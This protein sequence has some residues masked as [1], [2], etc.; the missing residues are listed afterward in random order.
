MNLITYKPD[1]MRLLPTLLFFLS[2]SN[3]LIAQ[4]KP[5][6]LEIR[7]GANQVQLNYD[8]DFFETLLP[9]DDFTL[10]TARESD[11]GYTFGVGGAKNIRDR[12]EWVTNLDFVR[13]EYATQSGVYGSNGTLPLQE[14]GPDVPV[15]LF[16]IKDFSF[17]NIET[18]IRYYLKNRNKGFFA[19][20]FLSSFI[21]LNTDW[22]FLT[23]YS[24]GIIYNDVDYST[25]QE[26]V[27]FKNLF[28]VGLNAGYRFN[29]TERLGIG[30]VVD[31]R[32]GLN[33]A[34]DT[35][36]GNT[37]PSAFGINVLAAWKF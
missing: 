26:E 33:S 23:M 9:T 37:N 1:M 35:T 5:F 16:G 12:F 20:A 14:V 36:A 24:P 30:P 27:N 22:N 15:L 29:I 17:L 6:V 34:V 19:G 31:Y 21:H 25:F 11:W 32:L 7:G 10:F 4:N 28:F 13:V 18:G 3:F 8:L 2:I